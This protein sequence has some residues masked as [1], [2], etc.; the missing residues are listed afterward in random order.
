MAPSALD[1]AVAVGL[2]ALSVLCSE[3]PLA[4]IADAREFFEQLPALFGE[5]VV[6][7][8]CHARLRLFPITRN[9]NRSETMEFLNRAKS[10]RAPASSQPVDELP[11][12]P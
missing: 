10:G 1:R 4:E 6:S 7:L 8:R 9:R 11:R 2:A 3:R 5:I 12:R